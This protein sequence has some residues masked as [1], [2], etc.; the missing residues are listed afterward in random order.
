MTDVT[1][2]MPD[3]LA[4]SPRLH[5]KPLTSVITAIHATHVAPRPEAKYQGYLFLEMSCF[6]AIFASHFPPRLP[7][8][9]MSFDSFF[10]VSS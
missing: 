10:F 8:R 3:Q 7:S 1:Q 6:P 5:V 9:R 2:A 4:L